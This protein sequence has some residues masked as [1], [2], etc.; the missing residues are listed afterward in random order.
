[1]RGERVDA[2]TDV[3]SLG[4]MMF[5]ALTGSVPFPSDN[6]LAKLYA[7]S[8]QPPPS[9]R[10][11]VPE[12]SPELEAAIARAMAKDPDQRF[13]SAG[14]FGRA[15]VAAASGAQPPAAERSVA[16]GAAA[17]ATAT[18]IPIQP[19]PPSGAPVSV[20]PPSYGGPTAVAAPKPR[21]RWPLFAGIAAALVAVAVVL[22]LVLG[23]GG[24]GDGGGKSDANAL[25]PGGDKLVQQKT[26]KPN[27]KGIQYTVALS[28]RA[29]ADGDELPLTMS[30]FMS[31]SGAKRE[32]VERRE[33][34]APPYNWT[35]RSYISEFTVDPAP[36][37]EAGSVDLSYYVKPGN[38][39][40]KT[41]YFSLSPGGISF[42][43]CS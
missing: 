13:P 12:L 35:T 31:Q 30:L 22:V 16:S 28:E 33:L 18:A 9:A 24:G 14:D 29:K 36:D 20:V 19:P 10:A 11:M 1:V 41:C 2:R 6:D 3:Y 5:Q 4:C 21:R 37:S 8:T 34:P 17:P 42:D 15:V 23:G 39:T 40:N 38:R 32:L 26:S 43:S 27:G 7:H 25:V